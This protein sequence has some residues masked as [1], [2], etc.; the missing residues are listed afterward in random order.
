MDEKRKGF[1]VHFQKEVDSEM[2]TDY[3]PDMDE[4]GH[5]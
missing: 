5:G 2:V 4:G 3:F 1:G